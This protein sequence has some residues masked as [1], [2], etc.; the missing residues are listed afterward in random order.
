MEINKLLRPH[1][2]SLKPYSSARDEFS[3]NA[4]VFLDANE[5]PYDVLGGDGVNRYPDPHQKQL[6][7]RLARLKGI[8]PQHIFLGNGSDEAIDLLFRAFCRPGVDNV[9]IQPP[10][11]GMYAV[12]AAINDV[13]IR[14]ALLTPDFQPDVDKIMASVDE[15]SKLLFI[16]SPNNP[17]GND[18]DKERV[19]SLLQSF[20]GLVIVDEAYID[21]SL[22]ESFI[23]DLKAYPNL[24]V[25]QTFSKAWALA[26]LRLG[27]AYA[28]E[29]IIRVLDHIKP[30]YNVNALT[31]KVAL[32]AMEKADQKDSLV[33]TLRMER[34]QLDRALKK[35]TLVKRTYP[36]NANFIL[37]EMKGSAKEIYDNLV[38]KGVIVRDR[39]KVQLCENCLRITVGTA[40][41]NQKLL[42]ELLSYEQ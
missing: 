36:S 15:N 31:Q 25:L 18:Q 4:S 1:L 16:C 32:E 23:N 27:V 11:Y 26:G 38:T 22:S 41:E 10:T 28:S 8:E 17:T 19:Y 9:I 37:A 13:E 24:V 40:E 21:F 2:A 33:E 12:S 3:G 6:K 20:P 35:S 7:D 42:S 34:D 14:E 30:P 29:E 39:S 5:N